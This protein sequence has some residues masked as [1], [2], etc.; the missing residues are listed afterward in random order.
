MLWRSTT[1]PWGERI[2]TTNTVLIIGR[3]W[4][5]SSGRCESS[6][7]FS[8]WHTQMHTSCGSMEDLSAL[9]P[10]LTSSKMSCTTSSTRGVRRLSVRVK[11]SRWLM[12]EEEEEGRSR[13]RRWSSPQ[14]NYLGRSGQKPS[15]VWQENTTLLRFQ[16]FMLAKML[17]EYV[18]TANS[19]E[20][21]LN[22]SS[23]MFFCTL[24]PVSPTVFQSGTVK[25]TC[26]ISRINRRGFNSTRRVDLWSCHIDAIAS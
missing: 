3:P 19:R 8:W 5:V 11:R 16:K 10:F 17:A 25:L 12:E 4:G 18:C 21:Q 9:C 6:L 1:T 2:S 22:A 23:V 14:Q 24:V 20:A 13:S 26:V 15:P 7:T